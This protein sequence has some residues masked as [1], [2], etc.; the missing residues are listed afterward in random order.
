MCNVVDVCCGQF[1]T[2]AFLGCPVSSMFHVARQ[3]RLLLTMLGTAA[4]DAQV[5]LN[6]ILTRSLLPSHRD[7]IYS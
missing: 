1:G 2:L 6:N 7:I 5:V 3:R 4:K